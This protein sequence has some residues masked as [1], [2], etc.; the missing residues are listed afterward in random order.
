MAPDYVTWNEQFSVHHPL[1][2]E[3][4]QN[5]L[6]SLN[7]LYLALQKDQAQDHLSE[8]ISRLYTYTRDHFSTE[9]SLLAVAH[10]PDLDE[11]KKKHQA[12]VTK[13]RQ[14]ADEFHTYGASEALE[15]LTFL[16][17]WWQGHILGA[18]H[19]YRPW[20]EKLSAS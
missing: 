10:Y 20:L 14:I 1:L 5:L 16:K 13:T 12:M 9:E 7:E 6:T 17:G 8:I 15:V 4:H 3:H 2:D 18:D 19:H 11:H